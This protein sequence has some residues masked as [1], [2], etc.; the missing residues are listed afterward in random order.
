MWES[1][2]MR[3][4][5]HIGALL[6]GCA[7]LACLTACHPTREADTPS[8]LSV[9][10]YVTLANGE[11]AARS[12]PSDDNRV[13]SVYKARGLPVQIV[14]ETDDWR[15]ICDPE[16]GLVWMKKRLVDGRRNV[17]NLKAEP[18]ALRSRPTDGAGANGWLAP[19]AL[20]AFDKCEKGW[21]R[22]KAGKIKGWVPQA[23]IWGVAPEPQ[24]HG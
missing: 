15:R 1:V 3:P 6:G 22:L 20:A 8:G 21:C 18:L 12:G 13:V 16:G 10:R 23:E 4:F 5:T 17:I 14:A 9:P 11:A 7:T 19:R 2:N 24:C